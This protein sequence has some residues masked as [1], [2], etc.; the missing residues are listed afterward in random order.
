M[1]RKAYLIVVGLLITG[2]L[3]GQSVHGRV[4]DKETKT[5][6]G[7]AEVYFPELEAGTTTDLEGNFEVDHLQRAKARL[8]ISYIGYETLD[9]TIDVRRKD[10]LVFYLEE[11]HFKL[12]EVIVSVPMG[13]L[14]QS[15][16]INV[17]HVKL[18]R[19]T[20]SAP[21]TL[22]E[23]IS[24]IPGVD[25][26][27]TGVGI[28]KPVIRGL[29]GNRIVTY[30]QGMRLENQ[31]WGDEHGLG[32]GETGI[33]SVEVIKGP[34]SLLYGA[35]ALGGVLYFIDERY[36]KH[37]TSEIKG[38]SAWMSNTAGTT[39]DVGWKVHR[40]KFKLNLFGA[41]ASHGDYA[42]PTGQRVF[43][44]RFDE[45]NLKSAIGFNTRHWISN[46]RYS[47]LL[48]HFGIA[49]DA[50]YVSKPEHRFVLPFQTI[51]NHNLS[52]DN[53]FF[54]GASKL[55]AVLGWTRN[56]RREFEDDT[57]LPALGLLLNTIS[58]NMKWH[59]TVK[60]EHISV[61]AGTQGMIQSNA[62]DGEEVLIPDASIADIGLFGL[63]SIAYDRW[64]LQAGLR[65]DNRRIHTFTTKQIPAFSGDY[66][67]FS[68]SFGGTYAVGNTIFR[69]N[70]SSGFR[71]PNTSEL[72][73]DGVH[74][75]TNR[76]EIG[77][78]TLT[79]E[80]AT[81]TDIE[82]DWHNEHLHFTVNPFVN[83]I[84]NYIYLSPTNKTKDGVPV[85]DYLQKNAVLYGGEVGIHYHPHRLHLLHIESNLST[86]FAEDLEGTPLPLIPQH[87][88]KTTLRLEFDQK[89]LFRL[90]NIFLRHVYKLRQDRVGVFE[91]IS[92]A[93]QLVD[94][95]L[96]GAVVWR[97]R[98]LHLTTGV[99]N[100]FNAM[101]VDHLSRF[102]KLSI[103]APGRSWYLGVRVHLTK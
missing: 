63:G 81:Q 83:Y 53:R 54:I 93:Y 79:S 90:S 82:L 91:T 78:N 64:Q 67:G 68:F 71:A 9:T 88:W 50:E 85:Y 39:A 97:G 70:V 35:D 31:Q 14:Q 40:G 45:R 12:K 95:G 77:N 28:G 60:S 87:K 46:V 49:E 103:P 6:I 86:V 74:E 102:N 99:K 29:S 80:K 18:D 15:N 27:S 101:Y 11:S 5:P 2:L 100:I 7:F 26:N 44:T 36:A 43:N 52:W 76:Y 24:D 62:N 41:Y 47:N 51:D 42:I 16:V 61:I 73:S 20:Q 69:A 72:L 34:A 98:T 55:D 23:S 10:V 89:G 32:I 65:W 57:Q 19:L 4:L 59:P 66:G 21:A 96:A 17:A 3:S 38:H 58:Y 8:R 30:A 56:Y 37:N 75:G 13:K 25:Q 84:N 1:I 92:P 33:E 22:A 48:N 94:A